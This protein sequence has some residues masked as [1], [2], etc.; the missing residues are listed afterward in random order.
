MLFRVQRNT[1]FLVLGIWLLLVGI[2]GLIPLGLPSLLTAV[3]ALIA[4]LLILAGR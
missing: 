2:N 4:G 3:L 1:G